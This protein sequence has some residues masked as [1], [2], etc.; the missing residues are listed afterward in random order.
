MSQDFSQ[1]S[2]ATT[3]SQFSL[4]AQELPASKRKSS[5]LVRKDSETSSFS[6]LVSL[7]QHESGKTSYLYHIDFKSSFKIATFKTESVLIYYLH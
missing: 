7:V 2:L 1:A 4:T 5:G 3:S 6:S